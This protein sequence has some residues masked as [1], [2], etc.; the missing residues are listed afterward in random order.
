MPKA[1]KPSKQPAKTMNQRVPTR[2]IASFLGVPRKELERRLRVSE[3]RLRDEPFDAGDDIAQQ[4]VSLPDAAE[5]RR[6]FGLRPDRPDPADDLDEKSQD[7][8]KQAMAEKTGEPEPKNMPLVQRL[9]QIEEHLMAIENYTIRLDLMLF[10][11]QAQ[12]GLSSGE[13][14]CLEDML[15]DVSWRM[16][17]LASHLGEMCERV[18][19]RERDAARPATPR[20]EIAG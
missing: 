9:G 16:A 7:I 10:A 4:S 12:V 18:D 17:T 3:E 2:H 8:R 11:N 14:N 15:T 1:N 6:V 19:S 5:M 20:A 13:P